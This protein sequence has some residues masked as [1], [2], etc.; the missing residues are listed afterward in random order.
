M[1]NELKSEKK[2]VWVRCRASSAT[3]GEKECDGNQA[4]LLTDINVPN[5]LAYSGKISR[6][7]CLTC[8]RIFS[9]R[10]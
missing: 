10:I 2:V 1:S 3:R 8:G 9:I 4:E 7:R 6:Y 5:E